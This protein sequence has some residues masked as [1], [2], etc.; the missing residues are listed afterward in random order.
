MKRFLA[1]SILAAALLST[2]VAVAKD[3]TNTEYREIES[4]SA[5][6]YIKRHGAD[7][8]KASRIIGEVFYPADKYTVEIYAKGK[9][10]I[11]DA[12]PLK[13]KSYSGKISVYETDFIAPGVY[14]IIYK[15][16]GYTDLYANAIELKPT[17]DCVIN[18]TFGTV[19]RR[20]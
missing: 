15:A 4:Y 13:T 3:Y 16:E 19:V 5:P 7:W 8:E 18:V 12:K 17:S 10:K 9:S 20:K 11:N 1:F 2:I 6:K 14:D